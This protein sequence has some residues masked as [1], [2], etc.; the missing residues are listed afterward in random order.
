MQGLLE[1]HRIMSEGKLDSV[2][3]AVLIAFDVH[4]WAQERELGHGIMATDFK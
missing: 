4:F 1:S 2:I 3:H